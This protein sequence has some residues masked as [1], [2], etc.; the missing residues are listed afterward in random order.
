MKSALALKNKSIQQRIHAAEAPHGNVLRQSLKEVHIAIYLSNYIQTQDAQDYLEEAKCALGY[1]RAQ[2][3]QSVTKN[4]I[5]R[6]TWIHPE[7]AIHEQ[8]LRDIIAID[9]EKKKVEALHDS[10][11]PHTPRNQSPFS[12]CIELVPLFFFSSALV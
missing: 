2:L 12:F 4:F 7:I 10:S 11:T 9:E 5:D 8:L 1:S 6:G 3:I